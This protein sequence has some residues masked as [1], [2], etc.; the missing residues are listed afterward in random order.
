MNQL[1]KETGNLGKMKSSLEN[2]RRTETSGLLS[3]SFYLEGTMP[4]QFLS[5][6]LLISYSSSR[7]DNAI[8]NH[9]NSTIKRMYQKPSLSASSSR[10]TPR[11]EP[12]KAKSHDLEDFIE[13]EFESRYKKKRKVQKR[14]YS[15]I[16]ATRSAPESTR[17]SASSQ[18]TKKRKK[19]SS[20]GNDDFGDYYC[21]EDE[22]DDVE[23]DDENDEDCRERDSLDDEEDDD[24]DDDDDLEDKDF[25]NDSISEEA[26]KP[27]NKFVQ[28]LPPKRTSPRKPV[29]VKREFEGKA[30]ILSTTH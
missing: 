28:P 15:D 29:P 30:V 17:R 13:D 10:D 18:P 2:K 12:S 5:L 24:D 27:Q 9:F 23:N 3:Q 4:R 21:D 14:K 20:S 16:A 26:A 19:R 7:T 8:K 11:T 25:S 1:K 22:D 6:F